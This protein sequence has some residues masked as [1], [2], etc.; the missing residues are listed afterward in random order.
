MSGTPPVPPPHPYQTP[1]SPPPP[2]PKPPSSSS[3]N[4]ETAP[5]PPPPPPQYHP[6]S[7]DLNSLWQQHH[8][9]PDQRAPPQP[10]QLTHQ[11]PD[12]LDATH[13]P[14]PEATL[15]PASASSRHGPASTTPQPGHP[16]GVGSSGIDSEAGYVPP[17]LHD[18]SKPDLSHALSTPSL[19]SALST[20][21]SALPS[22]TTTPQ[23]LLTP[24]LQ[25]NIALST[26]ILTLEKH[27]QTLRARTQTHLLHTHS[28][29]RSFRA[30]QAR[31]DEV[32]APFAPKGLYERLVASVAEGEG[33]CGA[34]E[35]SF[36][37]GE[38]VVGEREVEAWIRNVREGR[39]R[40]WRRKEERARWD[41]GRVGGWR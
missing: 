5:P 18:K 26:H 4:L 38:G 14:L 23:A 22:N 17:I 29:E 16:G 3:A 36:L 19:L 30:Q 40:W 31:M 39:A 20:A 9:Q 27:L 34:V 32:L 37:D 33:V 41:E 8:H 1:T 21:P 28:L 25:N 24:R 7:N 12:P 13:P 35:E 10:P 2:P 15:R 11:H 6:Q